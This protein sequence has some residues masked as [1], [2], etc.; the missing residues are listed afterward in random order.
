[1]N[2]LN[3]VESKDHLCFKLSR[4]IS[5]GISVEHDDETLS[6]EDS[7]TSSQRSL[8]Q[9]LGEWAI[10]EKK[11][12]TDRFDK[13]RCYEEMGIARALCGKPK[14]AL[15]LFE[16]ALQAKRK[17]YGDDDAALVST[18]LNR[19]RAF[20]ETDLLRSCSE[21]KQVIQITEKSKSPSTVA[22]SRKDDLFL[23]KIL[24]E[25]AH[26]QC[27]RGDFG[28]GIKNLKAALQIRVKHLG[29]SHYDVAW[30]WYLIGKAYHV[31]RDYDEA[32]T[33]YRNSLISCSA[34]GHSNK[35]QTLIH[36]IQRLLSDRTMLANICQRHW[37]DDSTV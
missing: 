23:A 28:Y 36:V 9:S 37:D 10:K 31:Q 22:T 24:L 27:R 20:G 11:K 3:L 4:S 7:F 29:A 8:I 2:P 13:G 34:L 6:L 19:A 30:V 17:E 5:D 33:A 12:E 21:Y 16:L 15:C 26:V 32:M 1:M 35:S 25:L 18:L 14:E